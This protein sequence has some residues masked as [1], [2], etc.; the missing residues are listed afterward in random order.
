MANTTTNLRVIFGDGTLGIDAANVHYIFS[1]EKG[2][3]ESIVSHGK[4]WLYRPIRPIFWRATTDNDRGNHFSEDSAMWLG[5]DQFTRCQDINVQ[6]DG[7][8]YGLPIAPLNNRFSDN[9]LADT[10]KITFT[11]QTATTPATAVTIAYEIA[12]DGQLTLTSSFQGNAAL[13]ELPAFGIQLIMPTVATGFEYD[14]LSGETYPD[15]MAGGSRGQ[16]Y[17]GGLPVTPYLV[18]QEMGM[19]MQTRWLTVTRQRT[20]NNVDVDAQPFSLTVAMDAQPFAFSCLPYTAMELEAATHV[21]ELPLARRTV[22]SIYGAVRGVG[23]IDSWGA[24]VQPAY[25]LTAADDR[26]FT[27]KLYPGAHEAN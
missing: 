20:L 8:D 13:P 11:F 25:R 22:L 9:E 10:V 23:G 4:E 6:V 15:R 27:V 26:T 18:P 24:N 1:Y 16:Y 7:E 14:G 5:A 19:H 17:V 3:L 21:E 2:G 12:A